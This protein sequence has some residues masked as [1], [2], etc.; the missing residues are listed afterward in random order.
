MPIINTLTI[1]EEHKKNEEILEII[2][3]ALK[4]FPKGLW[5]E[6]NYLGNINVMYDVKIRVESENAT[7]KAFIFN[8]LVNKINRIRELLQI[9]DLL[10]AIT[11]DPVIALYYVLNFEKITQIANLVHDYFSR[12]IGIVSLFRIGS[13]ENASKVVAHGLGH[14]RGLRH[15]IKPIDLMYE[16]LL[17]HNNVVENDGFCHECLKRMRQD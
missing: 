14:N 16:G 6:V 10:L 12:D 4:Y 1:N 17:E 5:K 2:W 8:R 11:C 3:S 13:D 7:Y 9:K 15:H